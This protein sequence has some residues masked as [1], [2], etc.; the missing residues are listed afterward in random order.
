MLISEIICNILIHFNIKKVFAIPGDYNLDL[1]N[2]LIEYKDKI[3]SIYFCN[4][5]NMGYAADG[6]SRINGLSVFITTFSV[7]SLS[8]LNAIAGCMSES[9]PT[10]HISIVPSVSN[11]TGENLLHH[12]VSKNTNYTKEIYKYVTIS[13]KRLLDYN[14]LPLDIA[15]MMN[16][17]MMNKKPV[18]IEIPQNLIN[19]EIKDYQF[20]ISNPNLKIDKNIILPNYEKSLDFIIKKIK[21][22]KKPVIMIGTEVDNLD[23]N[24]IIE[25]IN[26][27]N[28]PFFTLINSRGVLPENNKNYAGVYWP[29][30]NNKSIER[31][32][33][34]SD[35]VIYLGCIFNDYNSTSFSIKNKED[36]LFVN[37]KSTKVFLN[38]TIYKINYIKV[39]DLIR[40]NISVR[41]NIVIKKIINKQIKTNNKPIRFY[42]LISAV[43]MLI[44]DNS[45]VLT[46][47]GTSW[48]IGKEII[49]KKNT[50]FFIQMN[51]GSIGWALP[52]SLGCYLA[53]KRKRVI[54]ITGDGSIMETVQSI[55]TM[56]RY[57]MK[58]IIIIINNK[59]YA[60]ENAIHNNEY[61]ILPVWNFKKIIQSFSPSK[62][63][64]NVVDIY[65]C[66]ELLLSIKKINNTNLDKLYFL[67]CFINS[68]DVPEDMVR[69]G[70]KVSKYNHSNKNIKNTLKL[71]DK[72]KK[73]KKVKY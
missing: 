21:S 4:E 22:L 10:V 30:C 50:K 48:W 23:K 12:S 65:T 62:D 67:N 1:L 51:Y 45:I 54:L 7:G 49:L 53:D 24:K 6:Y 17:S 33:N 44:N 19:T 31:I 60:I 11:D 25:L 55:S 47:T 64:F 59:S 28:I 71:S 29:E 15:N 9:S 73:T 5:L 8:S 41:K 61:N 38:N 13:S 57:K 70:K 39:L 52:C 43:N 27:K 63:N 3:E 58:G 16:E 36:L 34:S 2:K 46:E 68:E 14:T 35:G 56:I 32:F 42:D 26:S 72:L 37:E 20:K 69:W 40:S 66:K 18:Y